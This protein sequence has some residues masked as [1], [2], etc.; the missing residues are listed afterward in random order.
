MKCI[1]ATQRVIREDEG[2]SSERRDAL[3][4][5]WAR[6]LAAAGFA[7]LPLPNHLATARRLIQ[8]AEPAGILLTGGGDLAA[9]GGQTPE[10]D[11]VEEWLVDEALAGARP[12]LGVCRGMQAIQARLGIPLERVPG[13]VMPTQEIRVE[14]RKASVNSYHDWGART[15]VPS[16]EVW[17]RAEDGVVK[18]VRHAHHPLVGIMWH[19][20][21]FADFREEDLALFQK[22]FDGPAGSGRTPP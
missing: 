17:A 13:H 3:D 6:F 16:L 11:E 21:R 14:G 4:Q 22:H 20:E 8:T 18:A 19:P 5:S 10:R 15:T 7:L 12:L 2:G 1:A 9:Y